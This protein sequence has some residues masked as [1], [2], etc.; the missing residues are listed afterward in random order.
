VNCFRTFAFA[1]AAILVIFLL[2]TGAVS[3]THAANVAFEPEH[4][5]VIQ[6]SSA[7]P[8]VHRL[9][10]ANAINL[11]KHYGIE[12]V[13]VEVVAY[14]PG[15]AMLTS[16]NKQAERVRSLAIQDVRFSAC[17]NTIRNLSAKTGSEPE[18]AEGVTVVPAGVAR[19]IELQEAG[20][21]YV[22]P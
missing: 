8:S 18:L 9:A 6:A 16:T 1:I 14:G 13:A 19:I 3:S 11:Q 20:Y 15:L 10:I 5:V 7:D 21:S 22:R 2:W 12:H 17:R 4:K